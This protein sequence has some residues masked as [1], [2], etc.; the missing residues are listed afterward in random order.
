MRKV[1]AINQ[2]HLFSFHCTI[3]QSLDGIPNL[4]LIFPPVKAMLYDWL[5]NVQ[6]V[7]ISVLQV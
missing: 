2:E 4:L 3:R 7:R 5:K 6:R 1:P